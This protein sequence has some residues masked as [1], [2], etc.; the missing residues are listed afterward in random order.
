MT[1]IMLDIE[2]LGTKPGCVVLSI[3]AV[4]FNP[5]AASAPQGTFYAEIDI[6]S[7]L[8]AGL[9][10]DPQTVEFWQK[11]T[12]EKRTQ[13]IFAN[14]INIY[15]AFNTFIDWVQMQSPDEKN[16][17]VW[18]N[19]PSFDCLIL[20]TALLR[21]EMEW[22]WTFRDLTDCRTAYRMAKLD[23]SSIAPS[24][25]AHH[26]LADAE[27]QVRAIHRCYELLHIETN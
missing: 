13:T 27:Y 7:S 6:F 10:I 11:Q 16:R 5:A 25:E 12:K 24:K 21:C 22:P 15:A 17:F 3:G 1:H 2:T 19:S 4:S 8:M 26:A 20:E 23:I 14:P 9:T 18:A